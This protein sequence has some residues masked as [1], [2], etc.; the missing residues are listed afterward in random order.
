M[1][2]LRGAM[3]KLAIYLARLIGLLA[4]IL[5]G[6][7]ILRGN[8]MIRAAVADDPVMLIYAIQSL[9]IGLAIVLGH[10]VWSG[11]A[12]PVV[13]TLVG[14]LIF[15]KG[16][17]LLFVPHEILLDLL[18]R[19]QY[20]EHKTLSILPSLVIGLYLTYAGFTARLADA[21]LK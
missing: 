12:L 8:A 20:G 21:K 2:H 13:V 5:D 6:A 11:G 10:N 14:W 4:L 1:T 3:S 9:A 16:L 19:M 17:L 15:A 7:F 18:E